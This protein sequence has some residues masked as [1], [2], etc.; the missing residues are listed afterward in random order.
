MWLDIIK[1]LWAEKK[2]FILITVIEIKGSAPCTA[3]TK[4]VYDGESFMGTV[5]G[6]RL[7]LQISETAKKLFNSPAKDPSACLIKTFALGVEL[8]QCCGGMVKICVEKIAPTE[9]SQ[10]QLSWLDRLFERPSE[11]PC[12]LLSL[13]KADEQVCQKWLYTQ[14]CGL[15]AVEKTYQPALRSLCQKMMVTGAE[16]AFA[17]YDGAG[18]ENDVLR[19][20]ENHLLSIE[21]LSVEDLLPV[22]L[23]G[24]GHVGQALVP[25]IKNLPIHLYWIDDRQSALGDYANQQKNISIICSDFEKALNKIPP[26]ACYLVITY[27]HQVDFNLCQHIMNNKTFSYLGLIGSEVKAKRFRH[28]LAKAGLNQCTLDRLQCPIGKKYQFSKSPEVTAISIANEVV[29]QIN[30]YNKFPC[31]TN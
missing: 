25:M 31:A 3:G 5:G 4:M 27:D 7:E 30:Q 20:L 14:H 21:R 17:L 10:S 16:H 9:T 18:D 23:F 12:L 22:A 29:E 19:T 2:P 28:R 26:N 15:D 6:G 1:P 24:A 13:Y 8:D 11:Q